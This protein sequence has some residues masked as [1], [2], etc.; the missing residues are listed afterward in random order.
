MNDSWTYPAV[1][2]EKAILSMLVD[3]TSLDADSRFHKL[4]RYLL[5][6][7]PDLNNSE[8]R[9]SPPYKRW[10]TCMYRIYTR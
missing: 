8:F 1:V 3:I 4:I 7:Y 5:G 9:I 10:K 6:T 2:Y